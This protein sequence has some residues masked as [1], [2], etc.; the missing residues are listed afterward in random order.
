MKICLICLE[1]KNKI[2]FSR[3]RCKKDGL[4]D[5]CRDCRIIL[6]RKYRQT[7]KDKIKK[8]KKEYRLKNPQKCRAR[9]ATEKAVKLGKIKRG[10]CVICNMYPTQAHHSDYSKPLKVTWLCKACHADLHFQERCYI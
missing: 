9:K 3:N 10:N 7:E 8:Y 4:Q 2:K 1:V 6:L 5:E